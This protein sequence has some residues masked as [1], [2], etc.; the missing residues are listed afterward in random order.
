MSEFNSIRIKDKLSI[1]SENT[2]VKS[3]TL[4]PPPTVSYTYLN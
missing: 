2:K 1:E 4:E 3:E